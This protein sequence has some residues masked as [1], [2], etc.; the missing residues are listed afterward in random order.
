M[1]I[2]L[3]LNLQENR[4]LLFIDIFGFGKIVE[5]NVSIND[6]TKNKI[7]TDFCANYK[8]IIEQSF[9]DDKIKLTWVSDTVMASTELCNSEQLLKSYAEFAERLFYTLDIIVRGAIVVGALNHDT[10]IIG[11]SVNEAAYLEKKKAKYPR[12]I[13]SKESLAKMRIASNHNFY[14][15]LVVAEAELTGY[16]YFDFA[17]FALERTLK[18]DPM[19]VVSRLKTGYNT[20][21]HYCDGAN[22]ENRHKVEWLATEWARAI[23]NNIEPLLKPLIP[24]LMDL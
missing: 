20:I 23:K 6:E 3:K 4:L 8:N 14:D 2:G 16:Y 24:K 1:S 21:K 15:Y 13:V 18:L 12:V 19:P 11:T 5:D 9:C 10:N 7:Y 17:K 22:E